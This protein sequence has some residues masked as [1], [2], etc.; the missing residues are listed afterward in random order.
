MKGLLVYL[1]FGIA[2]GISNDS[3]LKR[4][5][6]NPFYGTLILSRRPLEAQVLS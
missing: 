6:K 2:S 1:K 4:R 3:A 5:P